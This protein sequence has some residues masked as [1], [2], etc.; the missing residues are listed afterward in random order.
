MGI[1]TAILGSAIIG[2]IASN[3][4]S[5][6]QKKASQ[7][8]SDATVQANRDNIDFQKWLYTDQKDQAAPW[9]NAGADAITR[10]QQAIQNGTYNLDMSKID[11][12]TYTPNAFSG[13]I[14]LT[15]DPSYQFRL[16]QGVNA[17]DMSAAAKGMLQSGA[18]QKAITQYGQ[19]LASQEYG[20]VFNRALQVNQTNN[21]D[22][23][24]AVQVNNASNLNALNLTSGELNN[25]F[26]RTASVAGSGQ[27]ANNTIANAAQ[28]MGTAVGASTINTGNALATNAINQ[29]NA[30]ANLY[31]NL[32]TTA[33]QGIQNYLAYSMFKN[34]GSGSSVGTN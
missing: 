6:A 20:N 8:A 5:N 16:K 17:L 22:A 32:A 30:T 31:S 24:N 7:A 28:N 13:N 15:Q 33:N 9:Y 25:R 21:A 27:T 3:S 19:D 18:Q 11:Q 26:N 12:K 4:A 10:L 2:G 23:L 1:E 34:N 29:G 14:D